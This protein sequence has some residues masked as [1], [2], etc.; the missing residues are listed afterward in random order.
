MRKGAMPK[1]KKSTALRFKEN[2]RLMI[3]NLRNIDEE[4]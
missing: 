2:Q 1:V 4:I 3:L